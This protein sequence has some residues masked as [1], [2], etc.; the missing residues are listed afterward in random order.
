MA[1][2]QEALFKEHS[3]VIAASNSDKPY[4]LHFLSREAADEEK[5]DLQQEVSRWQVV[6][7]QRDTVIAEKD[8]KIKDMAQESQY[9]DQEKESRRL[10]LASNR[11]Y[12]AS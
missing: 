9:A 10:M 11:A 1:V 2:A 6:V 8:Q 7:K 4:M 5:K 12:L 3:N